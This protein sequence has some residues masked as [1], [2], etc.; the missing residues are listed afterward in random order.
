MKKGTFERIFESDAISKRERVELTLNLQ[1]VDR[2]AILEQ[3]SYNSGVIAMYT[4]KK[5]DG[6]NYTLDDICKVIGKTTDLIMPP[7]EPRGTARVTTED[8]FVIQ[9]D[10]WHS[11]YVSRPF[12]DENGARDWLINL[13]KKI[14]QIQY[15]P[16]PNWLTGSKKPRDYKFDPANARQQYYEYMTALQQKIPETVIL[17][18][19]LT[20]MCQVYDAMGLEIFSYFYCD[21]PEVMQEFMQASVENELRRIHA[22]SDA[23][24]SPVILIPEDFSAKS[25]PIF[26]PDF[27]NECHYPYLKKLT[28]AW[29]EHGIKVL[30]HSDGNYREVIPE[31]IGCG[32]DGFYCLEPACGMDIVNLKNAYPDVVWA[33]GLDGIELMEHG[34]PE[35][36]KAEVHRHIRQTNA[37]KTGGMFL[38]TASEINP[39]VKPENFKAMIQAVGE[40][41]DPDF[42]EVKQN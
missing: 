39:L 22:V 23:R 32:V 9:H 38:A 6:F 16:D 25:G 15:N 5:I 33:G 40:H 24:L 17:E 42:R 37:L 30:Y 13:T 20:G 29:H 12:S 3:L 14:R 31:L 7:A 1:P 41:R 35:Q 28:C 21:F 19:S 27:L 8:G 10:N 26:G 34:E 4:G 2:V 36:V 18:F 11:G